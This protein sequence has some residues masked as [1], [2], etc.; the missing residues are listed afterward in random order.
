M[1]TPQLVA[2]RTV[3]VI[4]VSWV[5][6]LRNR[7]VKVDHRAPGHGQDQQENQRPHDPVGQHLEGWDRRHR[8]EIQRQDPPRQVGGHRV[9]DAGTFLPG[10][11]IHDSWE[12]FMRRRIAPAIPGGLDYLRIRPH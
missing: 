10:F 7:A 8:L 11:R 4:R 12:L 9:D 6:P 5:R 2:I 3:V 1:N